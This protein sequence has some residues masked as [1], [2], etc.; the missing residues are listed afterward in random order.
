M[1]QEVVEEKGESSVYGNASVTACW[2]HGDLSNSRKF[3]QKRKQ[4][5]QVKQEKVSFI[6]RTP[7]FGGI[8]NPLGP[9]SPVRWTAFDKSGDCVTNDDIGDEMIAA[10]VPWRASS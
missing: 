7:P 1:G 3:N 10:S 2:C 6:F 4:R 9:S 8:D 5:I